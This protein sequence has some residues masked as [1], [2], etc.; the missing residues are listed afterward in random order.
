MG[1]TTLLPPPLLL[2]LLLP[3]AEKQKLRVPLW[4]IFPCPRLPRP[5]KLARV[6][7]LAAVQVKTKR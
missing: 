3:R 5:P 7:D 1:Q 6:D 4:A 2:L